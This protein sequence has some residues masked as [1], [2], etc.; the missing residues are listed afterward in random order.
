MDSI[1]E[2]LKRARPAVVASLLVLLSFGP[3][4]P[5]IYYGGWLHFAKW[6]GCLAA[7][8]TV[9]IVLFE[10]S[11]GQE[12]MLLTENSLFAR[13]GC[14]W[15]NFFAIL[16]ITL[17]SLFYFGVLDS[18]NPDG[19]IAILPTILFLPSAIFWLVVFFLY[20]IFK[21]ISVYTRGLSSA[22][23]NDKRDVTQ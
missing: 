17:V 5:L 14:V 4:A 15:L 2:Y 22:K 13:L 6:Y 3:F 23:A 8:C 21:R 9:V 7:S 20:Y 18:P 19:D 1:S 10:R 16:S 11:M 12:A